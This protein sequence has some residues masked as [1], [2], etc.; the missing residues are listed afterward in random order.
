MIIQRSGPV[1]KPDVLELLQSQ[2]KELAKM[3]VS[4]YLAWIPG[5]AG[6]EGNE[7]AED[8][9]DDI[10]KGRVSATSC[11]SVNSALQTSV[12]ITYKS[13][14]RKWECDSAGFH[15]RQLVARVGTRL[16]FS[17][18]H[19]TGISYCRLLLG[20]T[21]LKND[22]FRTGTSDSPICD[23]GIERET[24][25]HFLLRRSRY[26]KARSVMKNYIYEMYFTDN[27]KR[28]LKLT[29][30]V[31]LAPAWDSSITKKADRE[32]KNASFQFLKTVN[33]KA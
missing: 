9:S 15:T 1:N 25:D 22:S 10:F 32:I 26:S 28:H 16:V 17:D 31:L 23:C 7:R 18:D 14:Q 4:I 29:D 5:H 19:D 20:D 27:K 6:I 21:M 30:S 33:R 13:W 3:N 8:M 2:A 11:I 12:E 24:A